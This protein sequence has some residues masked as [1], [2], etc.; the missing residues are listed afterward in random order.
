MPEPSE[1][2]RIR[3]YIYQQFMM[4]I[5]RSLEPRREL[6]DTIL[7]KELED[8]RLAVLP[9]PAKR[10]NPEAQWCDY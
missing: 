6:G 1:L 2:L 10:M 7:F 3:H 5:L 9:L 8:P 4:Q